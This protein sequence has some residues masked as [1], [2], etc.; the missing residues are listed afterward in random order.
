MKISNN[1][2]LGE[3]INSKKADDKKIKQQYTYTYTIVNNITE[4]VENI[5][6]PLRDDW[7][8][9]CDANKLGS[10][11]IIIN[12]GYRCPE[13]NKVLGG[14]SSSAHLLGYAADVVPSNGK[15]N[16]FQPFII[17][18]LKDRQYDQL[19]IEKPRNGV[20]SWLHIGWKNKNCEQRKQTF[21]LV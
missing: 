7:S 14:S 1:F 19:I 18:W 17:E 15:M 13:L 6:Q 21:T 12:S 5:L 4:L 16:L 11:S 8:K 20:A 2:D 10:P 9:Y 3:F